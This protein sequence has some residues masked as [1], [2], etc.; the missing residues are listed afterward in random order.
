MQIAA[1]DPARWPRFLLTISL[2]TDGTEAMVWP[3]GLDDSLEV[4]PTREEI[5]IRTWRN[6]KAWWQGSLRALVLPLPSQEGTS[7]HQTS[8]AAHHN[9]VIIVMLAAR[10]VL[11]DERLGQHP[12]SCL[13]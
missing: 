8:L 5:T 12:A 4:G 2:E 6:S 9:T 13:L 7:K 3:I 11:E 10:R 1:L